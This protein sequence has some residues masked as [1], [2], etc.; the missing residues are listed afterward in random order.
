MLVEKNSKIQLPLVMELPNMDYEGEQERV[1]YQKALERHRDRLI[2]NEG[3][4]P[5]GPYL[6]CVSMAGRA[7]L[8]GYPR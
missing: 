6:P 7:L 1:Q 4:L 8:A 5:K 2:D 3:I